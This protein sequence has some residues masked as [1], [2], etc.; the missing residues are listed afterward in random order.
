MKREGYDYM[1]LNLQDKTANEKLQK[2]IEF[3]K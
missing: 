1:D 2:R 3:N